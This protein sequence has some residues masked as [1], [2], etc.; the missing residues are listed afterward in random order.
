M[1]KGAIMDSSVDGC[2][3]EIKRK[4]CNTLSD[5]WGHASAI[6]GIEQDTIQ[7]MFENKT[8]GQLDTLK[9]LGRL[10]KK[11]TRHSNR[12]APHTAL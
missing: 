1:L 11:R 12:H 7:H 2:A 9:K 10:P 6:K 4:H 5:R 3:N 8:A